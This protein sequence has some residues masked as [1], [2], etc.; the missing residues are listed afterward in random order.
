VRRAVSELP[1]VVVWLFGSTARG[2]QRADSDTDLA[3]LVDPSATAEQRLDLRLRL[4][5]RLQDEGVQRP[6]VI[7][8]NDAPLRLK[9]RVSSEGQVLF[10]RDEPARVAWTSRIF[11]EHADFALLQ[12]ELDRQMLGGH[13]AGRR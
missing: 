1:V 9:A 11:R 6:D 10:S 7:V 3:V 4:A 13:A 8:V 5:E 12:D 2:E